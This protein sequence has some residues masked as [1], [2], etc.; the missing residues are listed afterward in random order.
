MQSHPAQSRPVRLVSEF[1]FLSL[2]FFFLVFSLRYGEERVRSSENYRTPARRGIDSPGPIPG[3]ITPLYKA[4]TEPF[5]HYLIRH[6]PDD[7]TG[8]QQHIREEAGDTVRPGH[9][10]M[11][12]GTG[13]QVNRCF[14]LSKSPKSPHVKVMERSRTSRSGGRPSFRTRASRLPR[15]PCAEILGHL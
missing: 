14:S 12:P 11:H 1:S 13:D 5:S 4:V 7:R 15:C 2:P 8:G 9:P 10:Q 6:V 3:T